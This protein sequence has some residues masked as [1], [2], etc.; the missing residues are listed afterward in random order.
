MNITC[1]K[2]T[3]ADFSFFLIYTLL[4]FVY[5]NKLKR[6]R[7]LL[8]KQCQFFELLAYI[9]NHSDLSFKLFL[10]IYQLTTNLGPPLLLFQAKN[11]QRYLSCKRRVLRAIRFSPVFLLCPAQRF[12]PTHTVRQGEIYDKWD[13]CLDFVKWE[14]RNWKRGS[15]KG[16]PAL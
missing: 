8:I 11:G 12:F 14:N 15:G 9:Q 6:M 10:M 5:I 4:N 7:V 1:Y 13:V 16:N 3:S 2:K